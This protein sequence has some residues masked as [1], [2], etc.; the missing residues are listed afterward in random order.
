MGKYLPLRSKADCLDDIYNYLPVSDTIST[1]GQPT[2]AQFALVQAAGF[3][4]VV[5]LAPHDAENAIADEPGVLSGLGIKYTHIPVNFAEPT[6]AD[7]EDFVTRM[8]ALEGEKVWVHCAANMRVSAFIYRYRREI[9]G[10]ADQ[11][12]RRDLNQ[13]WE[14]FGV[15]KGFVDPALR[16]GA[17]HND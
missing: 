12:A 9:L 11:V 6:D 1:S 5:N 14:P 15:W 13:I 7:F 4:H 2:Q 17:D 16:K 10:V 8:Q 3:H